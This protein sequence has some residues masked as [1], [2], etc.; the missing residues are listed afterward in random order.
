LR[1]QFASNPLGPMF[2]AFI[3]KLGP[4]NK[5]KVLKVGLKV[6]VKVGGPYYTLTWKEAKTMILGS[7]LIMTQL[8]ICCIS[9]TMIFSNY[10]D[11]FGVIINNTQLSICSISQTIIFSNYYEYFE[12]IINNTQLSICS[13]S[14]TIIFSNYY[15]HLGSLLIIPNYPFVVFLKPWFFQIIMII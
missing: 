1:S 5:P 15:D 7:L 6:S 2:A 4:N 10:Y 11:Y 8:S 12:V 9:Q 14:Q 13:I 3:R